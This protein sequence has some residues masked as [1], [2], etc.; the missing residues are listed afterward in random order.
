MTRDVYDLIIVGG[1]PA[2]LAA[3]IYALRKRVHALTVSRDLGGKT[4]GRFRIAD[5]NEYQVIRGAETVE[6]FRRELDYLGFAHRLDSVTRVEQEGDR[7]LLRTGGGDELLAHAVVIASGCESLPPLHLPGYGRF[8]GRGIGYSSLSYGH[9]F[10]DRSV[11]IIGKGE[12]AIRSALDLSAVARRVYL[13]EEPENGMLYLEKIRSRENIVRLFGARISELLGEEYLHGAQVEYPG[14]KK[15]IIRLDGLFIEKGVKA[16]SGIVN[17]LVERDEDGFIR[18][19]PKCRTSR[20]GIFAAG[21]VTDTHIE[22]VLV[23]VGEGAKAAL[24]ACAWL[25]DGP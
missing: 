1:G 16:N 19:D 24:T 18:V 5:M 23:A 13:M 21:D 3:S 15:E 22:Q 10:L 8:L 14:G 20:P 17:G 7:F 12:R 2:G 4:N 9:L 6:R 25:V 11:L